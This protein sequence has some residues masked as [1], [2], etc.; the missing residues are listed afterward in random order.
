MKFLNW[1]ANIREA[2]AS[3]AQAGGADALRRIALVPWGCR[4]FRRSAGIT[5][6]ARTAVRPC[7][8]GT[9]GVK[10]WCA[11]PTRRSAAGGDGGIE[12][13]LAAAQLV[14][15]DLGRAV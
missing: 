4:A 12:G 3:A 15:E 13:G 8:P 1:K 14:H 5:A 6:R 7:S 9:P 2:P 11:A 10:A